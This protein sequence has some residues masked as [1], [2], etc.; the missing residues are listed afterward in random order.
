[1]DGKIKNSQG[2]FGNAS[3]RSYLE[4]CSHDEKIKDGKGKERRIWNEALNEETWND[5]RLLVR[6]TDWEV[7]KLNSR[8]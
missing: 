1:M 2:G 6:D 5:D 7:S 8:H 4:E 3:K